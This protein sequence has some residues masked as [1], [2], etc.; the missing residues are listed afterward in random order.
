MFGHIGAT[1]VLG[2]PGNPVSA[3]VCAVMFLRPAIDVMLGR[4]VEVRPPATALL[5]CDLAEND[6]RADYLRSWISYDAA[7]QLI[8]TPYPTQDSSM[9]SLLARADCL[10]VRPPRAPAIKAGTK[11]EI[12][13][14][15]GGYLSI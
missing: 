15:S 14:L 1:P 4:A 5:G 6:S 2:V 13:P 7:G 11:V 10:V 3:L 8:A 9:L 12:V